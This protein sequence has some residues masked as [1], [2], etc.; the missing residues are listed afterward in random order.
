MNQLISRAKM[1]D[2]DAFSELIQ[3][4]TQSMY[5]TATAI[6][7]NDEDAADAV[8]ETILICWEKLYQLKEE[9]YFK[10]WLTRILINEC[11]KIIRNG[12]K[13][14]Y[15]GELNERYYD[16]AEDLA[17]NL[18]WKEAMAAVDEK[19]RLVLL[20]FYTEGFQGKEIAKILKIPHATVRTRLARGR[21]QLKAYYQGKE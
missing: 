19:C 7:L 3:S 10:T 12:K 4:Q 9:K 8:Q 21:A 2:P 16:E 13:V 1:R 18:E 14:E 17:N 6:L 20:L 11:Y 5:K 15:I